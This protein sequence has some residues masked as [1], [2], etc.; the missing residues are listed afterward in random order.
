MGLTC[1]MC[2]TCSG[3]TEDELSLPNG[4]LATT[5]EEFGAS[6]RVSNDCEISVVS[7][8]PCKFNSSQEIYARD[9]CHMLIRNPGPFSPC[10]DTANPMVYYNA[11][12]MDVCVT[13]KDSMLCPVLVNY[14]RICER[15]GISVSNWMEKS[16]HCLEIDILELEYAEINNLSTGKRKKRA[17]AYV[18]CPKGADYVPCDVTIGKRTTCGKPPLCDP[19]QPTMMCVCAAPMLLMNGEC[20]PDESECYCESPIGGALKVVIQQA[21]FNRI[22]STT[23]I[24]SIDR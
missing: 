12:V 9:V 18:E 8:N 19:Q 16:P 23:D 17:T 20:V 21:R 5:L 6:Y 11:C 10:F 1:G 14:G 24:P 7:E 3:K 15:M 2:G 22:L 4:N 13:G